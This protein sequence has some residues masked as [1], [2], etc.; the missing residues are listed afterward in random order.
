MEGIAGTYAI[1]NFFGTDDNFFNDTKKT[2]D[3]AETLARR[4]RAGR[5]PLCKVRWGTEVTVHDTI[6]LREH[7]PV[8]RQSGLLAVWMG[9]EDL[10]GTLVKKG[11][12]ESKTLESFQLLRQNGILP[13][14]MMVHH[15]SQPLVTRRSNYGLINQLRTLR[16][17]GA[18]Y[19]QVLMLTP[20]PGSKWYES[21]FTSGLAFERVDGQ[22]IDPHI[23]DGNYVVASKHDRPWLK[24]L[25]LL[26][27]YTY[28]FNPLRMLLAT[29]WS[30]SAIPL[31]DTETRPAD[32]VQQ[33]PP[34]KRCRRRLYLK[35][36][37]FHRRGHP[38]VGHVRAIPYVPPHDRLG[39]APVPGQ[40]RT[41]DPVAREPY[42]HAKCAWRSGQ[43]CASGHTVSRRP[44]W[45]ASTAWRECS[46][47]GT[48][49]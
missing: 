46:K 23:V 13:V 45:N 41:F 34:W 25:N 32:E 47:R 29:I 8:I 2:L 15:D 12:S 22:P 4:V 19:T 40:D 3:I 49:K 36:R 37:P 9:V 20:S 48:A 27:G 30:K 35:L 10:T 33:Y 18:L 6:R 1:T 21:T 5:R 44:R 26:G 14:P 43:P 42:P 39:L 11:Q 31:L 16:K 38:G 24:Q 7:L 17:A 28:F